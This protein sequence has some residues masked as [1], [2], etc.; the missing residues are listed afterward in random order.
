L[1]L[2]NYDFILHHIPGKTNMKADI[3]LRKNQVDTKDNNKDVQI[4]KEE[5]WAR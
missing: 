3:L 2:Q 4:L 5:L 1:K